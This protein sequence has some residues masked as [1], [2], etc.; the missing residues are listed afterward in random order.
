MMLTMKIMYP[1]WF[2]IKLILKSSQE[3]LWIQKCKLENIFLKS[4]KNE[5][6]LK[7]WLGK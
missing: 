4:L 6:F 3:Y 7:A 1:A 5:E 2:A